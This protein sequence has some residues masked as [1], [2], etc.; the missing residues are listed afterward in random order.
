MIK[1]YLKNYRN[2]RDL[3]KY[4]NA[5]IAVQTRLGAVSPDDL[6][7]R[8]YHARLVADID[9]AIAALVDPGEQHVLRL[10]Y[11]EGWSWTKVSLTIHY[12]KSQTKRIHER[13][14]EHLEEI[15]REDGLL[16]EE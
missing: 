9:H 3:V 4:L 15:A 16:W 11:I 2:Y 6:Q 8:D 13:A 5:K 1:V 14:L 10:R 7:A 12:S